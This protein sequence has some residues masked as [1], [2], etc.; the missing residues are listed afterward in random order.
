MCKSIGVDTLGPAWCPSFYCD[1]LQDAAA[2]YFSVHFYPARPRS[3]S[4]LS[5]DN[6]FTRRWTNLTLP[7]FILYTVCQTLLYVDTQ[8]HLIQFLQ[9][10]RSC[11]VLSWRVS[12]NT[13]WDG[14]IPS[15][16]NSTRLYITIYMT[17]CWTHLHDFI[18]ECV[19]GVNRVNCPF[20]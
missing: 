4:I 6:P 1:T 14:P 15:S 5:C 19:W 7:G 2:V 10:T 11:S 13:W 3:C 9:T 17:G 16:E 20:I 8:V 12:C 18:L